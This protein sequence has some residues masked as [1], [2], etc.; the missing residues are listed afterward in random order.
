MVR[1]TTTRR[2]PPAGP[3]EVRDDCNRL[4]GSLKR[5]GDRF[6]ACWTD[7]SQV[8]GVAESEA[9]ARATLWYYQR[10]NRYVD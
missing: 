10:Q 7:G 9:A 8:T 4:I 5:R 1:T 2:R 3:L 6:V